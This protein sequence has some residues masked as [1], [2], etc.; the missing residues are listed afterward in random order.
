M[1][2]RFGAEL[3]YKGPHNLFILSKNLSLALKDPGVIAKKLRDDLALHRVIEVPEPVTNIFSMSV[4]WHWPRFLKDS[5]TFIL[6]PIS[7][8]L[9]RP[10]ISFFGG[11]TIKSPPPEL[12]KRE[13]ICHDGPKSNMAKYNG[14]LLRFRNV[15]HI[16][17]S[18]LTSRNPAASMLL[19]TASLRSSSNKLSKDA[20]GLRF[21]IASKYLKV[22]RC[23]KIFTTKSHAPVLPSGIFGRPK[24]L[25]KL[26][27]KTCV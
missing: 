27:E 2:L 1:I 19:P 21:S 6:H 15:K 20:L 25:S 23:S 7:A 17:D 22:A 26:Y 9:L 24:S 18:C 12:H 4:Y 13:L 16:S 14:L 3:G 10:F 8:L 11:T 5:G